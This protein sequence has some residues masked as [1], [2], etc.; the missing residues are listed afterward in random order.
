VCDTA[1]KSFESIVDIIAGPRERARAQVRPSRSLSS[2]R[3]L[4]SMCRAKPGSRGLHRAQELLARC[5]RVPDAP[6]ARISALK[7]LECP[8][9][10]AI[11]P[12]LI[13]TLLRQ[14]SS[15]I[16]ARSKVRKKRKHHPVGRAAGLAIFR[17]QLSAAAD[18]FRHRRHSV[19]PH[20]H[21]KSWLPA[22]SCRPGAPGLD[23]N[24]HVSIS[25]AL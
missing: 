4:P 14:E 8:A 5:H 20:S 15:Q 3:T 11:D 6:S 23:L 7:V 13:Y 9:I 10:L 22:C 25:R 2:C 16:R 1:W 24:W 17:R 19:H 21:S 18:Y 12:R